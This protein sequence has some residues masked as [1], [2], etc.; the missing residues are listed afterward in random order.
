M[1]ITVQEES[2]K[3]E[4]VTKIIDK[5]LRQIF[6]QEAT[7]LIYRHLENDYFL[8]RDEIAEKIDLF[9]KGLEDFLNSGACIVERRILEDIYSSYGSLGRTDTKKEPDDCDFADEVKSL[10]RRR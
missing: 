1:E 10:M 8:K 5:V 6:G 9:A 7:I 2:I 4:K 3:R